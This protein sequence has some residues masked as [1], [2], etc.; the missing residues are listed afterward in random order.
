M[1]RAKA[2]LRGALADAVRERSAHA[3]K[4]PTL[5]DIDVTRLT[6][7]K[8]WPMVSEIRRQARYEVSSADPL[9]L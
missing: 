1:Q 3:Q 2:A 5:P 9:A 8:V 7:E 4:L 6:L